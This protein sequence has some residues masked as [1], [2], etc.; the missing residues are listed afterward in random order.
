MGLLRDGST[1]GAAGANVP[2]MGPPYQSYSDLSMYSS[3]S[4]ADISAVVYVPGVT[5]PFTLATITTIAYS[6]SRVV[7]PVRIVGCANPIT[8]TRGSRLIAGSLVFATFDRYV[9]YEMLGESNLYPHGLVLAD[10]LPPFDIT[11]TA[12]NEYSQ[13]SRLAIRGV[14]IVDEGAVMGVNDMYMEQTHTFVAQDII[15]WIP[16]SAQQGGS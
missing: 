16:S 7:T 12:L 5:D 13:M 4:G 9:W 1:S 11:V 6:T 10:M 2:A 14:R 8:Y 15:P 3:F